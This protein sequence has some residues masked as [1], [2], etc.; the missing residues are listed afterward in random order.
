MPGAQLCGVGPETR[1]GPVA[2]DARRLPRGFALAGLAPE[3][4]AV[5]GA[6]LEPP[7]LSCRPPSPG[8]YPF[9][10]SDPFIFLECPHV[11]FCG[12]TPS[13]GSKTIRGKLSLVGARRAV[14]GHVHLGTRL[15]EK[16]AW[17]PGPLAL[18]HCVPTGR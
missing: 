7:A 14:T 10:K 2:R 3:C 6:A 17:S 9:Y 15:V 18:A 8:C 11:Y 5:L 16:P 1:D 4:D 13:F 12:N